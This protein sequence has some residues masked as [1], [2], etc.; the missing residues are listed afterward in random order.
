MSSEK[1][2]MVEEYLAETEHFV[3]TICLKGREYIVL[4]AHIT[5]YIIC[6]FQKG[7]KNERQEAGWQHNDI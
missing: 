1:Q 2:L 5:A 7:K 6:R 4:S 3:A